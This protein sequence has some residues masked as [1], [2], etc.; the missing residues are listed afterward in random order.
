MRVV[1]IC[2]SG[3][4][5]DGWG[6]QENLLPAYMLRE[7]VENHVIS[8]YDH[9]PSYVKKEDVLRLQSKGRKY[10]CEGVHLVR[11]DTVMLSTSMV[12]AK[13]LT[14]AL[15]EISP[16]LVFH[17]DVDF[18]SLPACA[19][20]CRRSGAVLF[21]DNHADEI[22]MSRN[23]LWVWLC[24]K[25]LVRNACRRCDDAVS[26]YYGVSGLRCDFL[27]KYY[28]IDERRI[29]LL[30][31]G[32]DVDKAGTIDAKAALRTFYGFGEEDIVIVSGGKMG[33]GK[34]TGM[35][36]DAVRDMRRTDSRV[37][38][39]LFGKVEDLAT[40]RKIAESD[41]VTL[42]GWCDRKRTL[43][44][45]KCADIACWPVHHT[46]LVEDAVSVCTPLILRKT[47]T[48]AHLIDGNG[49]WIPSQDL[50]GLEQAIGKLMARLTDDD[51]MQACADMKEKISYRTIART[52]I[53]DYGKYVK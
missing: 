34:G 6:Y 49:E 4:Y 15:E 14:R 47:G 10:D 43:E 24:H 46:T 33:E 38:L 21:V 7:G 53:E 39:L 30:P 50:H 48:V 16:D 36:V 45:L 9:Y 52:V 41:F 29:K 51:L 13:G 23:R 42:Y 25:V 44:L 37:K 5:I 32:A 11:L 35:L 20:F 40:E 22:N 19:R 8:S 26:L 12:V 18:T 27:R 31:I 1:H 2:L 3:A 17:H 28:H